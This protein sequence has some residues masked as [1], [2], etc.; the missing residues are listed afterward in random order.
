MEKDDKKWCATIRFNKKRIVIGTFTIIEEAVE[1]H[2]KKELE[3]YSK[4]KSNLVILV[5]NKVYYQIREILIMTCETQN[6][7]VWEK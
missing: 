1:A 5:D 7:D 6:Q 3:L 4:K 2:K